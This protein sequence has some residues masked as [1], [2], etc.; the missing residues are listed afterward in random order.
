MFARAE[1]LV[2]I[3]LDVPADYA[4]LYGVKRMGISV[5][6][7]IYT[8]KYAAK[9]QIDLLKREMMYAEGHHAGAVFSG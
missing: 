6:T 8:V 5:G 1:E 9:I 3:G 2:A 7:S 4:C